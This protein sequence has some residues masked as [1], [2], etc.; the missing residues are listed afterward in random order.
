MASIPPQRSDQNTLVSLASFLD[1]QRYHKDTVFSQDWLAAISAEDILRWMNLKAFGTPFPGPDANPTG[2]RSSTIQ[3]RKK[4]IS[5]FIPN[6]PHPWD[7]LMEQGNPTRSR[8][9][10]DLL[11]FVKKKE[12]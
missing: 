9:I 1:G 3:F 7:S 11:K 8:E 4:S 6:K 12:V 10:L 2:C 5:F